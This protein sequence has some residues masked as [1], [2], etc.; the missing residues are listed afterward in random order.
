MRIRLLS[1]LHFEFHKDDGRGFIQGLKPRGEDVLVLA[2]DIMKMRL[3]FFRVLT[4]FR[5]QF[6]DCPIVIIF[7][8]HEFHES[9]RETVVRTMLIRLT[10]LPPERKCLPR[11]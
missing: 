5:K 10:H 9:N 8:N 3:G 7:G 11:S 6:P 2:G 1:D 4:L